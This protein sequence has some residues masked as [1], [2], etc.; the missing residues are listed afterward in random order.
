MQQEK[1][2]KDEKMSKSV[3]KTLSVLFSIVA[4]AASVAS[5]K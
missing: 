2:R 3:E 5:V 1:E 4:A